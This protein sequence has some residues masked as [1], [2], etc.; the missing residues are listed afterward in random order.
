MNRAFDILFSLT[1]ILMLVPLF[2]LIS[3]S[4]LFFLG[5][6]VI[7]SQL[8][9]GLDSKPFRMY[10]F[11]TM[12]NERDINGKL[13]PSDKRLTR[14]GRFLRATS[15]DEIPEFINVLK[16]EMSVVGPRPLLMDYLPLFNSAQ[17][18]RHSVKPGI[19]GWAQVNGRNALTWDE[20]FEL[21]I[22]Y[23][24][25]KCFILDLKIILMTLM[26]I[27]KREGINH[28]DSIAMPRFTGSHSD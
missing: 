15:L 2:F 7:F 25:N 17:N 1:A 19:T 18:K 21:D 26:K 24:H 11:R 13:L 16:G 9:P 27:L 8:R 6:P 14:F 23:V 28:G 10:K 12:T 20:K 22:W 4:V 3:I 5:F